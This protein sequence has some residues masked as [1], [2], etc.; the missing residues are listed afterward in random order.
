MERF[1]R[2]LIVLRAAQLV[3]IIV[4]LLVLDVAHDELLIALTLVV[5]GPSTLVWARVLRRQHG[6]PPIMAYLDFTVL[7]VTIAVVPAL[8]P[9]SLVLLSCLPAFAVVAF[10]RRHGFTMVLLNVPFIAYGVAMNHE[11][12]SLALF[13][14]YIISAFTTIVVVGEAGHIISR[15]RGDTDQLIEGLGVAAWDAD[16]PGTKVRYMSP[17]IEA[18]FGWPVGRW[19]EEGFWDSIVHREDVAVIAEADRLA[20]VGAPFELRYRLTAADGTVREVQERVTTSFVDGAMVSSRGLVLDVTERFASDQ[21]MHQL[22]EIVQALP[23]PLVVARLDDPADDASLRVTVVNPAAVLASGR[24]PGDVVG[25]RASEAFPQLVFAHSAK[26][27]AD[28]A[29]TGVARVLPRPVPSTRFGEPR[30]FAGHAFPLPDRS[31]ALA[32]VDVTDRENVARALLHQATH[33]QLTGLPNRRLLLERL[34]AT[35]EQEIA[36]GRAVSLI[37]ADLDQFKEVNDALGHDHGDQLLRALG[38]RITG[39]GLSYAVFARLGGDEF[40]LVLA[41]ER[42]SE[43]AMVLARRVAELIAEPVPLAHV[44]IQ[45]NASIGVATA[46]DHA[47]DAETLIKRADVAMY[48]AKRTGTGVAEYSVQHDHS[49]V[50]RVTLLGELRAAIGH[51]E[52]R[53]FYQPV[54]DLRSGRAVSAEALVRWQHPVHGLLVP[55]EFLEMAEVS[56]LIGTLSEWVVGRAVE[57]ATR[58]RAA[59]HS[60]AVAVNLSVRNLYEPHLAERISGIRDDAGLPPHALR[61]ELT[62]HSLMHEPVQAATV[63]RDMRT[64]GLTVSIDDFGTAYSSL[65][66][67]RDLP[68]DELK[69]D[70]AF[71]QA[72]A[73]G[74]ARLVRSIIDLGHNLGL[75]VVA[76]G[77]EDLGVAGQLREMGCDRAQGY[78][79]ARPMDFDSLLVHLAQGR[80]E[81][82]HS[83]H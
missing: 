79:L 7:A 67:L 41:H 81:L 59:G 68:V 82:H 38:A 24:Q 60:I 22:A 65:W 69:I 31:V 62:E 58:W 9:S 40:A 53:L 12:S 44:T 17:S 28:V 57:D 83:L 47:A 27:F 10:G 16:E 48:R 26:F 71:I 75:Q 18:M 8:L 64:R 49:S 34:G 63:L 76:E 54:Y 19:F 51:E 45:T 15:L 50:R 37:M 66:L 72:M 20:A 73:A 55:A 5:G 70:K 61:V 52:L 39:G 1:W 29:R 4:A 30:L 42:G 43:D 13:G 11:P 77:V 74:D 3:G 56:G 23:I 46:P 2:R 6:L 33:D 32:L 21:Q 80:V 25:R 35:I 36:A 78:A 14:L